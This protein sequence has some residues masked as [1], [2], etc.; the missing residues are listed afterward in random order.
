MPAQ[1][2]VVVAPASFASSPDFTVPFEPN[3]LILKASSGT[4]DVSF[5][6]VNVAITIASTDGF[7]TLTTKRTKI[8]VRQN[9]GASTLR[10][11]AI[12]IC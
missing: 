11:S 12:T 10:I 1:S 3:S 2:A 5:D 4:A 6:G 8:W 9:G 7:L